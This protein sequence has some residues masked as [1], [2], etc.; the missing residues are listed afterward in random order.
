MLS[1][2]VS[3]KGG[4]NDIVVLF[5]KLTGK[6]LTVTND[7]VGEKCSFQMFDIEFILLGNHNLEDDFGI[8]FTNYEIQIN[9][10]QLS[11]GQ[12]IDNYLPMFN[13]F[14]LYIA[15]RISKLLDTGVIIVADLQEI[16]YRSP[17]ST[18]TA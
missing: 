17:A 7:E 2:F 6:S 13:S 1:I 15:A 16:V 9:M 10:I 5:E 11:S 12:E 14:A 8:P 3:Y 18:A 4:F